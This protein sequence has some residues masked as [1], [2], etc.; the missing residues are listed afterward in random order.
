MNGIGNATDPDVISATTAEMQTESTFTDAGWD[1]WGESGNGDEDIWFIRE[2]FDYPR[3]CYMHRPIAEA[4][5]EQDICAGLDG[6]GIVTLDGSGSSDPDGDELDYYWMWEIDG[7]NFEAEGIGPAVELP[8]GEHV[9]ELVVSDG[10]LDSEPNYVVVTVKASVEFAMHLT[11]RVLNVQSKGKW[12]KAHFVLPAEYGVDDVDV[13]V[14]L[15]L[16]PLGIESQYMNVFINDAGL[17]CIEAGFK[18]ADFGS[19]GNYGP[20]EITVHS[21]FIN[22]NCFY[23]TATIKVIDRRME[24][25]GV[26]SSWWLDPDCC[27]PHWCQGSDLNEDGVVNFIDFALIDSSGIEISV[28]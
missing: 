22:G 14:L 9:I 12:V 8:V 25:L 18:R 13:D 5:E 15:M 1:F 19:M 24:Q 16:E 10:I 20:A 17:T 23:G 27:H 2:G 26:L 21:R 6:Y 28:E 7:I 11:P 4:G 3:F